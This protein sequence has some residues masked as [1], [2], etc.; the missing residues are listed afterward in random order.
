MAMT[1]RERRHLIAAGAIA[2]LMPLTVLAPIGTTRP[3]RSG[4]SRPAAMPPLTLDPGAAPDAAYRRRLFAE[5]PLT[6]PGTIGGASDAAAAGGEAGAATGGAP[7]LVG[8]VGRLGQ[9]AVALV[10]DAGGQTRTLQIGESI[11]GWQLAALAID[12]AFF[13]R[14]GERVRVALPAG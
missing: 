7:Q 6:A 8:I 3:A 5:V 14:G 4:T 12:A 9:D 2:V 11:D 10:R 13:T 1:P